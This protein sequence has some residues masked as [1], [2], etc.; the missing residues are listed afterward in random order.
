[1]VPIVED[2]VMGGGAVTGAEAEYC[3]EQLLASLMV[4]VTL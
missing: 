1:M 4:T 2:R 3:I